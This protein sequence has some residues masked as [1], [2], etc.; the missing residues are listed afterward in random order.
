MMYSVKPRPQARYT[1]TMES[2]DGKLQY[3]ITSTVTMA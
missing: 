3:G 1:S 2:Y